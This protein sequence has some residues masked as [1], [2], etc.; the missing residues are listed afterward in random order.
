MALSKGNGQTDKFLF[1][2]VYENAPEIQK[3]QSGSHAI[4][5]I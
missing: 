1:M 3:L 5:L 4:I 2:T